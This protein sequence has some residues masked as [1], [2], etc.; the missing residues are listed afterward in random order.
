MEPGTVILLS[1]DSG[2]AQGF[3]FLDGGTAQFRIA[4][5]A[6]AARDFSQ[7][8]AVAARIRP[9]GRRERWLSARVVSVM[10]GSMRNRTQGTARGTR[11]R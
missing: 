2:E 8:V 6:L 1:L 5:E 9:A 3:D 10:A 7:A 11:T 4:P